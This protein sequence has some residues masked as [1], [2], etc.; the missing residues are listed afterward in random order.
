MSK[1][2]IQAEQLH[3]TYRLGK[4]QLKVLRGV[5]FGVNPGQF[6]AIVGASGSGKSTLL[7]LIGLLDRPDKG[8]V[9][10]EGVDVGGLSAGRRNRM[11][12]W[13]VG[14]VFQFYHLLGE[15]NILENT[16]APAMVAR[17]LGRWFA[18]RRSARAEGR[19]ILE[20]LGLGERLRHR[21]SELSGGERQRVAIARA[22]IN[23]PKVLLADEPTGN[24]DSKTGR[25]IMS[26]LKQFNEQRG[27]T[28][29]MVTHDAS[30]ASQADR[31]LHLRDG[32]LEE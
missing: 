24:L 7:H 3:K 4:A 16:L 21:P 10:L 8:K 18:A 19:E 11:R 12:C 29:L 1:P 9:F 5:S 2:I 15:L 13:D 23:S 6:V 31:V 17:S 27:Q 32:R 22:L 26:I 25:H 20:R 28:I 14:F 30:L